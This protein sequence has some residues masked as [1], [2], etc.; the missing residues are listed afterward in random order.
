M[1]LAFSNIIIYYIQRRNDFINDKE[2]NNEG[3]R[4]SNIINIPDIYTPKQVELKTRIPIS[5]T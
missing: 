2:K 5:V 4:E 3:N 1:G